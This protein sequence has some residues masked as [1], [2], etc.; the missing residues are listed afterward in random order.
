MKEYILVSEC[1]AGINCR[2]D[3]KNNKNEEIIKFIKEN[4]VILV[5][6]EQLG[7]LSTPRI[8]AEILNDKVIDKNAKDVTLNFEKGAVEAL[9]IA[10]LYNCKKAI[11]KAKSPSCGSE[12]IYDGSHTGT[13]IKGA[14]FTCKLLKKNNIQIVNEDNFKSFL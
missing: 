10:K 3:G 7:G 1:L 12:M 9:S 14:G 4:D 6:P 5:C 8:P 11:L 2:Y 13:L